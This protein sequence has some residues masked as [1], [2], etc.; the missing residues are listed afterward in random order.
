MKGSGLIVAAVI[1]TG[2]VGALYWSNHHKPAVTTEASADAAPKILAIKTPD[3][4]KF[5]LKKDGTEQV[6][7]ER[8]GAGGASGG[9]GCGFQLARHF[10]IVE[11]RKIGGREGQQSCSLRP[12]RSEIGS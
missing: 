3:I 2:L 10:F 7:A 4:S 12:G 8:N 9:S 6:G 1:L 11:F 5:D